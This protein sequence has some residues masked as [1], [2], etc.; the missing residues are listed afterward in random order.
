MIQI[1]QKLLDNGFPSAKDEKYILTLDNPEQP[2]GIG[3]NSVKWKIDIA[4]W[5]L[6]NIDSIYYT[7]K[8]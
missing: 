1:P 4:E 3:F 2:N 8:R 7:E 5:L 6:E